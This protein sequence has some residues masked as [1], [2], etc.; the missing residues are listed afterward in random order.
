MIGPT[1]RLDEPAP[2]TQTPAPIPPPTAAAAEST[3]LLRARQLNG[4]LWLIGIGI[5]FLTGTF[6]PGILVLGGV[7]GYLEETARGR[8]QQ[9]A[10]TLFF[11]LGLA[12]LFSTPWFW[13]GILILIGVTALLSPEVRPHHA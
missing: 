10:R 3:R 2:V 9:A 12:I 13:P 1:T 4:G 8:H 6:W 11:M 7:S 5:L